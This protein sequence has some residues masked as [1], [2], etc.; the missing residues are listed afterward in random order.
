[1]SKFKKVLLMGTA[2]A[3]V[4]ALSIGGTVAYLTSSDSEVNV[5]TLGNVKIKQHEYQRVVDEDGNYKTTT[6][7]GQTSYV[8][9]DFEQGKALVPSAVKT[10]G[11]GWDWDKDATIRMKQVGSYGGMDVFVKGSNAQDKFVTVENTGKTDAYVRTFVAFECGEADPGLVGNS[12]HSTWTNNPIGTIEV[13]G[14]QYFL[15]EYVYNGG[16]LSDGSWR[17]ENGILP[18]GDTSYPSLAQVYLKAEATNEDCEKLDGNDNGTLD[19]L[20]LSQA[21]QAAGFDNAKAALDT[22]FGVANTENVAKWFDGIVVPVY[23][24]DSEQ[25]T[26]VLRNG[27]ELFLQED[28]SDDTHTVSENI[29][30]AMDLQGNTLS[31][32]LINNGDLKA[33]DGELDGTYIENNGNATFTDMVIK[34]GTPTDYANIN[35]NGSETVYN[36]VEIISGGGGIGVDEGSKVVFNSGS[37]AV[38][39][40]ST[41]GRYNI[42]AVGDGTEVVIN[43]G[44]FSF[45]KT[46]NQKRAYIYA[47]A[48]ATVYVKGGTFGAASTRSGYTEGILGDGDVII[49]GGTFGF[50]PSKWVA[51]GYEAVQSGKTWTVSA[52]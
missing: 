7:D 34:A 43:D 30:V 18:A 19:I 40:A 17:H 1:M 16:Q 4:A 33:S 9:E 26:K 41:S 29:A 39:S 45:S 47:G 50:N 6:I 15:I 28:I 25:V 11:T 48:G 12:Y 20:V 46:L 32:I 49:T 8:L 22:G 31:G 13:D 10:N 24:E 38:N 37:I 42:Y 23:A 44:E 2:Y 52:K 3:L 35:I 51:D 21:V 5:M 36:N 14:N 27:G